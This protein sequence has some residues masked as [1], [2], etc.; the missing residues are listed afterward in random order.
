MKKISVILA[1]IRSNYARQCIERIREATSSGLDY[2]IVVVSPFNLDISDIKLIHEEKSNGVNNAV[3]IGWR[4]C[5]GE[6]IF[7]LSDDQLI[8]TNCL[9]NLVEQMKLHDH[10][11]YLTGARS[12]NLWE[13]ENDQKIYD[14]YYPCNSCIKKS[15]V[16]KLGCLYDPYYTQYLADPDLALRIIKE[17]GKVE[18][19]NNA[20][21]EN[22]NANDDIQKNNINKFFEED[23]KKFF[24]R[25]HK[26]YGKNLPE[27]GSLIN[28][29][30][31]G[32]QTYMPAETCSRII[33][34]MKTKD[35][36]MLSEV[37]MKHILIVTNKASLSSVFAFFIMTVNEIPIHYL[38][39]NFS[40]RKNLM[41]WLLRNLSHNLS[42]N[43]LEV[44]RQKEKLK[45]VYI[46]N[47]L[48]A[49]L[50]LLRFKILK[51][52]NIDSFLINYNDYNVSYNNN[53][54]IVRNEQFKTFCDAIFWIDK[55]NP[56]TTP[57]DYLEL[58]L[59]EKLVMNEEQTNT[60]EDYY[61]VVDYFLTRPINKQRR[62][63]K[64]GRGWH[65]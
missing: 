10:E 13:I 51:S 16:E 15:N 39:I 49:S 44:L 45:S 63:N 64:S 1:S 65:F 37:L 41:L 31:K 50:I 32:D 17:G 30:F 33:S 29:G 18:P 5:E 40:L 4:N 42:I 21:I 54:F 25:W 36:G 61:N 46:R 23:Y 34:S 56:T 47:L 9:E 14:F 3:E 22:N 24:E 6:Y 55:K 52:Q 59:I 43:F 58:K 35:W 57:I 27:D 62:G 2:E 7:V 60:L 26:I 12:S 48:V 38:A 19:C 11:M 8:Q 28:I 20:W 53:L